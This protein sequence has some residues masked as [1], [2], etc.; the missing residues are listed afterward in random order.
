L[1]KHTGEIFLVDHSR[2]FFPEGIDLGLVLRLEERVAA[3]VEPK[4]AREGF[5][6]LQAVENAE[7]YTTQMSMSKR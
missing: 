3:G 5:V 4:R 2:H 6:S 1:F 7:P